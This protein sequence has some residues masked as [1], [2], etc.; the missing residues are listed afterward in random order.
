MNPVLSQEKISL[1]DIGIPEFILEEKLQ[2]IFSNPAPKDWKPTGITKSYYLDFMEIIVRNAAGWVDEKGAVIDPYYKKEWAQTTPRFVSSASILLQSGRIPELKDIVFR[3]MT[4]SCRQLASGKGESPDFWMRELITAYVCLSKIAD[5][6]LVEEWRSTLAKIAPEKINKVISVDGSKLGELH[7][8]AVYGSAGESMRESAGIGSEDKK[9]LWGKKFFDKYISAQFRHFNSFGMYR[10]P[11]DPITYD[12]TTRLQLAAALWYGYDWKLRPLIDELLRRGGI[13]TLFFVSSGGFAPFGGR[14]GQFN[15]QEAIIAALC[16][17]EA[18]RYKEKD[19]LLSGAFKRQA[20]LSAKSVERWLK[21]MKPLRHIKNG[22]PPE[23]LHGAD[24]YGQYSV[25]S[26]FCASVFGL[27]SLFA[28]DEIKESP[29]PAEIGGYILEIYPSFHKVFATCQDTH[30]EIDTCADFH[31]D[32]TGLGR[33]QAKGLPAE[34]GLSMPFTSTPKFRLDE[35]LVPKEMFSICPEWQVSGKWVSLASL[36]EKLKHDLKIISESPEQLDFEI[37]YSHAKSEITERY[38]LSRNKLSIKSSALVDGKA[39][40][41]IRYMVP[42]LVTDGM[43]ESK[44][45]S[46]KDSTTIKYLDRSFVVSYGKEAK[47][48]LQ[49][50]KFANRN[51][52]YNLLVLEAGGGE[53]ALALEFR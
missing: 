41:K 12:I 43:N 1:Q 45:E 33:F 35:K 31:Y 16:E 10:D 50:A 40:E 30:I 11:N 25:Y 2:K 46:G 8:W 4:Y 39:V 19:P 29:C 32:S 15:F 49:S 27:A 23:T 42:I 38:I 14:S 24:Q 5:K 53:I 3:A 6:S 21:D 37:K 17:I 36:S 13:T 48:E 26:L 52:V 18:I 20:H 34:L 51:G 7:N 9:A 22:F 44:I 47:T 28:D